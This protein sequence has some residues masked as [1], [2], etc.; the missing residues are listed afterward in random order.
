MPLDP[1]LFMMQKPLSNHAEI[2]LAKVLYDVASI[3]TFRDLPLKVT[4]VNLRVAP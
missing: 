1:W 4:D 2:L 3:T